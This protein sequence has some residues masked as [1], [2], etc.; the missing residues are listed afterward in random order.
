MRPIAASKLIDT[1][2][3]GQQPNLRRREPLA[4]GAVTLTRADIAASAEQL[5][6]DGYELWLAS[7]GAVL[8]QL[9]AH[10]LRRRR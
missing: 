8:E 2:I 3:G 10:A 1:R 9:D 4:S 5:L 6:D 7:N